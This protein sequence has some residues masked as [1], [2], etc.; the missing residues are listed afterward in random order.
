MNNR[1]DGRN[2]GIRGYLG[3]PNIRIV[4]VRP[5]EMPLLRLR[6]EQ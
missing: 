6:P 2:G 5:L 3:D 4:A 1:S